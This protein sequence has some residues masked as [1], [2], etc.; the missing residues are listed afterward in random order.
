MTGIALNSQ[1]SVALQQ[2]QGTPKVSA[3][4]AEKSAQEFEAFFLS[5]M[6][7][8]MFSGIKADGMFGGGHGE[9]MFKSLMVDEY[10]KMMAKSGGVGIADQV[11]AQM[12]KSQEVG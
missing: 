11:K 9:E 3:Q 10:G 5:Q 8:H 12:L 4:K 7:T 1:A 2:G 6:L